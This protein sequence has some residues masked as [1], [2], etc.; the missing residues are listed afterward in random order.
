M[1]PTR[2]RTRSPTRSTTHPN[3]YGF[4]RGRTLAGGAARQRR[5]SGKTQ[6]SVSDSDWTAGTSTSRRVGGPRGERTLTAHSVPLAGVAASTP[7]E[8]PRRGR[9]LSRGRP[10]GAPPACPPR[11]RLPRPRPAQT[12]MHSHAAARMDCA[13]SC[14]AAGRPGRPGKRQRARV[15]MLPGHARDTPRRA[16]ARSGY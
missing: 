12:T 1:S 16:T 10:T 14:H 6:S 7:A 4:G 9:P 8:G 5:E 11:A 2:S 3:A 15:L 13:R